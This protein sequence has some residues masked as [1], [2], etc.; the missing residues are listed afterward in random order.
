[1]TV[2]ACAS[3]LLI[4]AIMAAL[5]GVFPLMYDV[6]DKVRDISKDLLIISGIYMVFYAF[7][8]CTYYTIRSGG[9]VIGVMLM[10]SGFMCA[11]IL[12][13][14][15]FFAYFTGINIYLLFAIG[16]GTEILKTIFASVLL[17]KFNWARQMVDKV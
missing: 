17:K 9:R 10:D 13:I 8:V 4:G 2:L 12:P 11:I 7:N 1:M 3:A 6:S 15:A 14:T 5:S 16:Q